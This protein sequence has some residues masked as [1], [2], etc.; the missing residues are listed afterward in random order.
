MIVRFED[1]SPGDELEPRTIEE[2]HGDDTKLVAALLQDPYPPHFDRNRAEELDYPGLL[3]Q[4]PANLSYLLQPVV[5]VLESPSD[6]RSFDVR[7]HDMVFEGQTV[8]ATATV[9]ETCEIDG[10]GLVTFD[11]ALRDGSGD[12]TVRGTATARLPMR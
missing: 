10:D 11:L 4:G 2:L 8:T 1:L 9:T 7:F 6:L 5:R 12:L 3:N